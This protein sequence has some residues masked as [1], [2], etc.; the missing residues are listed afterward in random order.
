MKK[1]IILILLSILSYSY[2]YSQTLQNF[3][4]FEDFKPILSNDVKYFYELLGKPSKIKISKKRYYGI[5]YDGKKT[6]TDQYLLILKFSQHNITLIY[7][8]YKLLGKKKFNFKTFLESKDEVSKIYFGNSY[9]MSKSGLKFNVKT[10]TTS[11]IFDKDFTYKFKG[12]YLNYVEL[13]NIR[14]QTHF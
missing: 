1:K 14:K 9:L 3:K 10:D 4:Y 6:V 13:I 8:D 11:T 2:I 12:S 7:T 5:S